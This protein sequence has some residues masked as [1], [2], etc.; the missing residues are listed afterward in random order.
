MCDLETVQANACESGIAALSQRQLQVVIAQLLCMGGGTG[1]STNYNLDGAVDP[2]AAPADTTKTWTYTNTATGT[3]W[4][5]PKNGAAW[6][7]IV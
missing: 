6:Q 7:Q 4:V 1:I 3:F 2:V 5:W